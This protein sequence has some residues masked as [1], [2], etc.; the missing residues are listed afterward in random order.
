MDEPTSALDPVAAEDV[1]STLS[2]LVHDLGLTVVL[3]EHRLER[4]VHHADGIVLVTDGTVSPVLDPAV[5]M[6]LSPV[7]PPVIELGRALRWDCLLY[8]SRC[9]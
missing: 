6:A 8:T 5:A 9:V 3:A 4:V 7:A 1:L 2:R